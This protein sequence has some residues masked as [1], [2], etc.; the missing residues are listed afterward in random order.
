[1]WMMCCA[2]RRL[3]VFG[4]FETRSVGASGF[5]KSWML[6]M[7]RRCSFEGI[8]TKRNLRLFLN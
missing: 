6:A 7:E 4:P 8:L 2:G 1:M 3:L 5:D